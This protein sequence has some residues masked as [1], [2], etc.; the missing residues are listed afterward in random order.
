MFFSRLIFQRN[1]KTSVA[2]L[3]KI[4]RVL[5]DQA[6]SFDHVVFDLTMSP[7]PLNQSSVYGNGRWITLGQLARE[8]VSTGGCFLISSCPMNIFT[9]I[10]TF[11]FKQNHSKG[12]IRHQ[13][14]RRA[15]ITN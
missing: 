12:F 14:S 13:A 11:P 8:V 9:T 4:G 15:S 6:I 7:N 10:A 3:T 2:M 1:S 5:F